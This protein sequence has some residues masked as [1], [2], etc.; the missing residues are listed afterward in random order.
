MSHPAK[1]RAL[2][3]FFWQGALSVLWCFCSVKLFVFEFPPSVFALDWREVIKQICPIFVFPEPWPFEQV[4]IIGVPLGQNG[5]RTY[6]LHTFGC[7]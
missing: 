1:V 4:F 3:L 7:K 2:V 6:T 5:L